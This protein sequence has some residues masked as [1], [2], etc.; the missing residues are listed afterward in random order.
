MSAKSKKQARKRRRSAPSPAI[1]DVTA[2]RMRQKQDRAVECTRALLRAHVE[3]SGLATEAIALHIGICE[4][5]LAR[6]LT[7]PGTEIPYLW[8][9]GIL[10][11]ID[12]TSRGFFARRYSLSD[13]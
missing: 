6:V 8:L 13:R 9:L 11:A 7:E 4:G 2:L 1:D 3:E 10:E 5:C 12:V